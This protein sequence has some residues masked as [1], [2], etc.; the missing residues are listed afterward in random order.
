MAQLVKNKEPACQSRR[1]KRREF[2][3]HV[4][5]I[6]WRRK[7]QPTPIF[8]PGKFHGQNSPWGSKESDLTERA[9]LPQVGTNEDFQAEQE[10]SGEVKIKDLGEE[11]GV[12]WWG[13][14]MS[15]RG[16]GASGRDQVEPVA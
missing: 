16:A 1:H 9:P 12:D 6:P 4:G 2:S 3:P 11:G 14:R 5:K 13:G 8:L 15:W 7:W 10:T